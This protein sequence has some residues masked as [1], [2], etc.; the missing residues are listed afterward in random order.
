MSQDPFRL[1][2]KVAL[3]TGSQSGIGAAIAK[4][5]AAAGA[6][7][8][9]HGKD[10]PGENTIAEVR[11]LGRRA[12]G[13]TA[14]L[15]DRACH[16]ELIQKTVAEFGRIDIL[17]NNAGLIRRSPAV[18]YSDEDW[19]LLI[20]VNLT[21][22]FRLCRM[23]G[24]QMISQGGGSI[25]NIAS[26]LSFQGGILVPAYAASKG[27]VAQ[28]TKALANE[29]APKGVNVNAIAPGYIATANTAA[30]RADETRSRQILERIPAGR[31]GEA[32]DI[33]GAALFLCSEASR[34]VHGHVLVVDGGWMAR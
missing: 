1:D 28:L 33:A 32:S 34:Y 31:W 21:A 14:D 11:G 15:A 20:E 17:V 7:I 4:Q 29:W 22:T 30:L 6:D 24:K 5:L 26:L 10:E 13:F 19:D 8:A 25:V 18:E 16:A 23:A 12:I 9:C 27:G 3:V 2:G